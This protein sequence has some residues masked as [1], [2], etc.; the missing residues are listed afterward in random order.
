VTTTLPAAAVPTVTSDHEAIVRVGLEDFIS[1]GLRQVAYAGASQNPLAAY[2]RIRGDSFARL[3]AERG[4]A[5][6]RH[7]VEPGK[8][9]TQEHGP[10]Q[11]LVNWVMELPKP[12]GIL[13][14]S[15]ESAWDVLQACAIAGVSVP[16]EAAVLGVD[17]DELIVRLTTPPLSSIDINAERVGFEAAKLLDRLLRGEPAPKEPVLVPPMGLV[18]RQSTDVLAIEDEDVA[19]AVKF[20]REHRARPISVKDVLEVVPVSRRSLYRKFQEAMGRSLAAEIRL[21]H[22]QQAKRLLATTDWPVSRSPRRP[23]FP[24][25]RGSGSCSA[26]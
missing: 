9:N 19:A 20:I 21:A 3:A 16:D 4:V 15:D 14:A 25:R 22:I 10:R 11:D 26:G 1:R 23:G 5:C 18:T 2:S 13:A 12:V 24:G 6:F 7:D 17:N 8:E